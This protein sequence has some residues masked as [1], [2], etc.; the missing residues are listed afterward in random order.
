MS[1]DADLGTTWG[2]TPGFHRGCF[3]AAQF[4]GQSKALK[5]EYRVVEE[6]GIYRI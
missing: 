4:Q 5:V 3:F 6:H 2:E 1:Q